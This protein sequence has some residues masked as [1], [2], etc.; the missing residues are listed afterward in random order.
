MP[1]VTRFVQSHQNYFLIENLF[2]LSYIDKLCTQM[3]Y[4]LWFLGN[5]LFW[6]LRRGRH[7]LE[8]ST[9][10]DER[11]MEQFCKRYLDQ[12]NQRT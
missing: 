1:C 7:V 2:P 12:G 9:R 3:I 10:E 11:R 8:R 6:F 4:L 5:H